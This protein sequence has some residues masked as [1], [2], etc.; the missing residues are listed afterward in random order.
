[1]NRNHV[2]LIFL[3]FALAGAG[4]KA[5]AVDFAGG[6]GEPNDP[7]QIG[8]A[9]Q[10]ISIGSDPNVLD[11]CYV[12]IAN[13]DLDPCL[14]GGRVFR[15]AVIAP[16]L[17]ESGS[18]QGTPFSGSFDGRGYKV[19]G[20]TIDALT[21]NPSDPNDTIRYH[22]G[23]FGKIDSQGNVCRVTVTDANIYADPDIFEA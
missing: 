18:F 8:T 17:G 3:F 6:S 9:E 22:L 20:L 23:L 12:L 19:R 21:V 2:R 14:P 13:I 10:L 11:K 1:M 5:C 16:D 15:H 4:H 7:Y